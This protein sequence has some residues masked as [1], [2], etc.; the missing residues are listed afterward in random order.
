M[1]K[2]LQLLAVTLITVS[3]SQAGYMFQSDIHAI[4]ANTWDTFN[5]NQFNSNLGTLTGVTFS[6]VSC[7]NSGSYVESNTGSTGMTNA[8]LFSA[9]YVIKDNQN[10]GAQLIRKSAGVQSS[11]GWQMSIIAPH[12][13][14]TN[15]ISGNNILG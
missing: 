4:T 14:I 11:P 9:S 7:G 12:T 3:S 8:G 13:S 2:F 15:A 1:K 10:G 5:F 6:I